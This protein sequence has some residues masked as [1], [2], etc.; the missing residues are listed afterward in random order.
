MKTKTHIKKGTE[1]TQREAIALY[2]IAKS[3][4]GITAIGFVMILVAIGADTRYSA[5]IPTISILVIG[6]IL[7]SM[8]NYI[9]HKLTIA[10]WKWGCIER[11]HVIPSMWLKK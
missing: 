3:M 1:I 9:A 11:D 5:V 10:L 2:R 6:G 7:I 4:T 8:S